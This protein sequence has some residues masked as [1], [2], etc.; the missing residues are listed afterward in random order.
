MSEAPVNVVCMKWGTKYGPEYVN[1]LRAMVS[2]HL[3]RPHRFVCLTDDAEGLRGDV[4]TIGLPGELYRPENLG[5]LISAQ[6]GGGADEST[7]RPGRHPERGWMKVG[8]FRPQ[9]GDLRG[10][11]LFLDLDV[12]I[13]GPI[14][15]LFEYP[16]TFCLSHDYTWRGKRETVGNTSV[17]RFEIGA[18]GDVFEY[19]LTHRSEITRQFRNEQEYVSHRIG[20]MNFWPEAWCPSF[21][22]HCVPAWPANFLLRPR[23]PP[24]AKVIV[25]H[26]RPNPPDALRGRSGKWYRYIREAPWVAD[27]WRE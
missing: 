17:F 12:L 9:L 24:E 16:G 3:D 27:H 19:F 6:A 21:K 5:G 25:F 8:M 15:A 18:H 26:G 13:V 22:R 14:G 20:T 7:A 11:T 1:I 2:R 23:F 10:L 4:E